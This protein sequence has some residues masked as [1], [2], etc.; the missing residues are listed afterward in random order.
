MKNVTMSRLGGF[1]LIELLVVV[2]IIGILA[3]IAVPQ[4][5]KAVFKSQFAEAFNNLKAMKS[6]L[7]VCEMTNGRADGLWDTTCTDVNNL[8][9]SIGEEDF[10]Q[11][12][13]QNFQYRVER[14][15]VTPIHDIAVAATSKKWD[16]CLCLY[17]D[18]HFSTGNEGG[19][20]C[21]TNNYPNFDVAKTL[22]IDADSNCYCC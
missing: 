5:Q 4:Y 14:G 7:E 6:A 20:E 9:I 8:D 13:T 22:N 15:G 11:F 21:Y 2:L 19:D 1:T 10:A 16:V 18:G 17:D 3:A 12:S